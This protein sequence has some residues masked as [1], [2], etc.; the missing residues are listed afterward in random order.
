VLPRQLTYKFI[1]WAVDSASGDPRKRESLPRE[2]IDESGAD[3]VEAHLPAARGGQPVRVTG[4]IFAAR[5]VSP[6]SGHRARSTVGRVGRTSASRFVRFPKR[7]PRV[8]KPTLRRLA[9]CSLS[10]PSSAHPIHCCQTRART[11]LE[12]F[13]GEGEGLPR[14]NGQVTNDPRA[15]CGA[16]AFW[17]VGR[18]VYFRNQIQV[19]RWYCWAQQA[20]LASLV[21]D[22]DTGRIW[23]VAILTGRGPDSGLL[24]PPAVVAV[25]IAIAVLASLLT[26][27]SITQRTFSPP[28]WVMSCVE[29]S[30]QFV[31]NKWRSFDWATISF[32]TGFINGRRKHLLKNNA[33]DARFPDLTVRRGSADPIKKQGCAFGCPCPINPLIMVCWTDLLQVYQLIV[34]VLRL[35]PSPFLFFCLSLSFST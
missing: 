25:L 28:M 5:S 6:A 18:R 13:W 11:R 32:Q 35:L 19:S 16:F 22:A 4:R 27:R 1:F 33:R 34:G 17:L 20:W 31:R 3:P 12:E 10:L 23:I 29:R 26:V 8:S 14:A 7:A 9:L 2:T 21:P 24:Q 15:S 30:A